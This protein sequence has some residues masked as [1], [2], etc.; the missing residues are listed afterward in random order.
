MADLDR[1]VIIGGGQAGARAAQ[2]MRDAGFSGRLVIVAEE[3]R[4]PYQ[5]PPLSKSALTAD[6]DFAHVRIHEPDYYV[7]AE[8]EVVY[9]NPA[10]DLD[11][12]QRSVRLADGAVFGYDRL[13]FATGARVRRLDVPGA[14]KA[15]V[16]YLRTYDDAQALRRRLVAG[17]RV[18]VI[19]GG[20][21]GLEVAAS[22]RTLGCAVTVLESTDR[23]MGRALAREVGDWFVR[24]H[25]ANG[26]DMRLSVRIRELEGGDAVEAVVLAD[27]ERIPVDT[28]LV[29]IG[30]VPN[31][32]LAAAAGL[33]VDDGIVVDSECRTSD[34]CIYAAGDV[35][36]QPHP[37]LAD[38]IRLESY[39]NAQDQGTAAGRN[40]IGVRTIYADRLWIWTDQYNVNLQSLGVARTFDQLVYRGDPAS[41][42]FTVFY[43]RGSRIAGVNAINTGR[44]IRNVE[45]L[46][47]SGADV[48][49]S[50]LADPSVR[51]RDLISR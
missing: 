30:I 21:I 27:G 33:V 20:F 49:I 22:A 35:T 44:D 13:L 14:D 11:R 51:Y 41:A 28:V 19:G 36:N 3:R 9:G 31:V 4:P 34:D 43:L 26:V 18:V 24:L 46:M 17:S 38:P 15:G 2:A 39:Q 23:L 5:R 50:R 29:G 25:Q 32:E 8:I 16:Q 48:D 45:R 47:D 12:R 6:D 42:A 1:V 40:V 37:K 10:V 7:T